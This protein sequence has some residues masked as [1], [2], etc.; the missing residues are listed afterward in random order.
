[1]SVFTLPLQDSVDQDTATKHTQKEIEMESS[2]VDQLLDI[3]TSL[4]ITDT[5]SDT[6]RELVDGY[7]LQTLGMDYYHVM[8]DG[9]S[10]RGQPGLGTATSTGGSWCNDNADNVPT[11]QWNSTGIGLG[12]SH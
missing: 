12:D 7:I 6:M 1:M 5:A 2:F 9:K 4:P 10:I 8:T 3:S 11:G